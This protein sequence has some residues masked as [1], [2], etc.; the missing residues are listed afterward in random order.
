MGFFLKSFRT[1]KKNFWYIAFYFVLA[2]I[3]IFAFLSET[4]LLIFSIKIGNNIINFSGSFFKSL[5]FNP[6]WIVASIFLYTAR[7]KKLQDAEKKIESIETLIIDS[8]NKGNDTV[9]VKTLSKVLSN[10]FDKNDYIQQK[11]DE[12]ELKEKIRLSGMIERKPV[13]LSTN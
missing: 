13:N 7:Y 6:L 12:E 1:V 8:M 3:F 5:W 2:L 4:N 11:I 10:T 9:L